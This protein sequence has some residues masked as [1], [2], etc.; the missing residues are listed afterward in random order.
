MG[1]WLLHILLVGIQ[2]DWKGV[3][4]QGL[5]TSTLWTWV[6]ILSSHFKLSDWNFFVWN[7]F[8][9]LGSSVVWGA[10]SSYKNNF[11][12]YLL[13]FCL[14]I[15][16]YVSALFQPLVSENWDIIQNRPSRDSQL[17]KIDMD[18]LMSEVV[19]YCHSK[20]KFS[21]IQYSSSLVGSILGYKQQ[22]KQMIVYI[23]QWFVCHYSNPYQ[24]I[25]IQI[26]HKA[27]W[28]VIEF[29]KSGDLEVQQPL[30]LTH[31]VKGMM[32]VQK[33]IEKHNGELR[34]EGES[35]QI[36][37]PLLDKTYQNDKLSS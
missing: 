35:V 37:L 14:K 17:E 32:F 4:L 1:I 25:N 21:L 19:D 11:Y 13:P 8:L 7:S 18:L 3:L 27:D 29:K 23:V 2:Y 34:A 20:A 33:S 12:Y 36:Y 9:I 24:K 5:W 10:L 26:F 22:I 6:H 28:M 31:W 15:K 30:S 16:N